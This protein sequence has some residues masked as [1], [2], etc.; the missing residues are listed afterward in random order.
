MAICTIT[1]SAKTHINTLCKTTPCYAVRLSLKGG[2]CA[3]F[4]YQWNTVTEA[5]DNDTLIDTGNGYL[6]I[7]DMSIAFLR[8]TEIDY[9]SEVTGTR[10][11]IRNPNAKSSCGCGES[12]SF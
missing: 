10:M 9:V 11:E 1:D 2:G 12:V 6:A 5:S 8:G 4:E 3:G 7:D